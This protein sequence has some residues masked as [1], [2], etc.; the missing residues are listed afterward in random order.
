MSIE[1]LIQEVQTVKT[2]VLD[3]VKARDAE[4]KQ[5]GEVTEKTRT[6]LTQATEKLDTLKADL[7]REAT[8]RKGVDARV[9]EL[10]KQLAK[11]GMGGVPGGTEHKSWGQQFAES[12]Q[13]K[14][15]A[16][17]GQVRT[18]PMRV[19][20]DLSSLTASA[21]AL[22]RP[23][24]RPDVVVPPQRPTFIR[25][26]LPGIPTQS[27]AVEVMR[28]LSF[29]NNANMQGVAQATAYE[30][31]NKPKSDITYELLTV[32]IRTLAH[33]VL[34]S[35]QIMSDARMLQGLIDN[36]LE[37]GLNLKLDQQ[38]LY[39]AGT[40]QQLTG[41]MVDADVSDIGSIPALG[42]GETVAQAMLDHIRSAVTECQ[43]NEFY[44]IN[45]LVLNPRDW[46]T[47]ELAKGSDGHYIW[48]TV[49]NGGEPRL[50]R[51]PVVV[52]NAMTQGDFILGDWTM[53]ATI[54]DREDL[55]IRIADQHASLFLQNGLA[56]LAEE[57]LGFGIELP[58]AFTKGDF[59]VL[60]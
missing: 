17:G 28:Q 13:Y 15:A 45:G 60:T 49:P 25:N 24:R 14:S 40:G 53:G 46:E 32:N 19:N 8:E 29:T 50:W 16:S 9:I 51:V 3:S 54:Y 58:Q 48:V 10:E 4:L 31:E 57:R 1:T 6:A 23:D 2:A 30:F 38:L 52:T 56:V 11:I 44:N 20:K 37:Y 43:V 22:V 55:Q 42:V 5:Y 18:A 36:R 34:A 7:D 39:G 12:E 35:R 47:I 59:T 26:L 33:H 41:L 21:G 27:N